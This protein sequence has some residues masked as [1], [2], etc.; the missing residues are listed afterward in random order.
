MSSYLKVLNIVMSQTAE[1]KTAF[2][3]LMWIK[4]R[5]IYNHCICRVEID[6]N[7]TRASCE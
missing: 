7:T 6:A 1:N 2:P 3:D 4:I 5:V